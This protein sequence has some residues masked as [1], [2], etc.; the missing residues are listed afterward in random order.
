MVLSN[1]LEN[2][3]QL[4]QVSEFK[5]GHVYLCV[6]EKPGVSHRDVSVGDYIGILGVGSNYDRHS[7]NNKIT[8]VATKFVVIRDFQYTPADDLILSDWVYDSFMEVDASTMTI[9]LYN[10]YV[11]TMKATPEQLGVIK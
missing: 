6:K 11:N 2:Y 3:M 10:A 7:S 8:K 5:L 9:E 4:S 1:K